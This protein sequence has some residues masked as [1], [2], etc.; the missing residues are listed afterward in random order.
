MKQSRIKS[1][2]DFG[3]SIW[4]DFFNRN[5]MESG[6]LKKLINNGGI[7]GVTSNPSIFENAIRRKADYDADIA[8]LSTKK[9]TSEEIFKMLAVKDIQRAA[10]FFKPTYE[11]T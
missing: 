9:F 4:L 5:I 1:I 10:D 11:N 6:E 7:S 8:A 3:Q 2:H